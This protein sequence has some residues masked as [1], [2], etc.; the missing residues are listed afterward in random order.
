MIVPKSLPKR[1]DPQVRDGA[2]ARACAAAALASALALAAAA[3]GALHLGRPVS[4]VIAPPPPLL[5]VLHNTQGPPSP[6]GGGG[7]RPVASARAVL[8]HPASCTD[9][10][11]P[12][13]ELELP[14]VIPDAVPSDLHEL[15][16]RAS[17]QRRAAAAAAKR[18]GGPPPVAQQQQ[19]ELLL[20]QQHQLGDAAAFASGVAQRSAASTSTLGVDQR[21]LAGAGMWPN[22]S[23]REGRPGGWASARTMHVTM[24]IK[25]VKDW[26]QLPA[27][28]ERLGPGGLD[29]FNV[30]ALL[31]HVAQLASAD[32]PRPED[33]QLLQRLQDT[34]LA[35]AP[36]H[37][38][39]RH[40]R[41]R[42]LANVTWALAKLGLPSGA[43][44]I[45]SSLMPASYAWLPWYEPQ[46]LSNAVWALAVA[47]VAPEDA[48][49][50][51]YLT[52]AYV[53]LERRGFAPQHLAN[54]LWALERQGIM[55]DK[56]RTCWKVCMHAVAGCACCGMGAGWW[57]LRVC[58]IPPHACRAARHALL[59]VHALCS[60]HALP[61]WR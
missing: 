54:V 25:A 10:D 45:Q 9:G 13:L 40:W 24:S 53:V 1:V 20:L 30:A 52:V 44:Y 12:S 61:H 42:Q 49:W 59:H 6:H 4:R 8:S 19:R 18:G 15:H 48:W 50:E 26:R 23:G 33:L 35:A 22:V 29:C 28:V 55:P 47:G 5:P 41:P 58:P 21:Q 27:L 16:L 36:P 57:R 32:P 46:H 38:A 17:W 11:A 34:A 39:A 14:V 51:E 31:A 3:A 7:R 43:A 60:A 56:V 2:G 37:V